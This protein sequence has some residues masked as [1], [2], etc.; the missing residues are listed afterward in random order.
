MKPYQTTLNHFQL[1]HQDVHHLIFTNLAAVAQHLGLTNQPAPLESRPTEGKRRK[2]REVQSPSSSD[3]MLEQQ[4]SG[5]MPM[6]GN[7]KARWKW[8]GA[9]TKW[10]YHGDIREYSWDSQR[11]SRWKTS[12]LAAMVTVC[13]HTILSIL[14]FCQL[15]HHA[16]HPSSSS[17][18]P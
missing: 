11:K 16:N 3:E 4:T 7:Q 12:D 17:W 2:M 18:E 10:C 14:S 8:N 15:H 6:R 5:E 13:M 1:A 9:T